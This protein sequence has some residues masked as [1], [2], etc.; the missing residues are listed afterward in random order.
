MKTR[1]INFI[2]VKLET[3]QGLLSNFLRKKLNPLKLHIS[4]FNDIPY[5]TEARFLPIHCKVK[6]VDG[7]EYETQQMPQATQCRFN[8]DHVFLVG[9]QNDPVALK[10]MFATKVIKVFLL[11]NE[12]LTEE[13]RLFP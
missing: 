8:H 6:F 1:Q 5:K 2:W 12:E 11:D 3:D 4:Q 9:K 10:E 13:P 7:Q